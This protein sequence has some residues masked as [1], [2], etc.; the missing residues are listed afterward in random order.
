MKM[1]NRFINI[2]PSVKKVVGVVIQS[3]INYGKV[4]GRK[5]G[6]TGEIGEVL[7]C[8]KLKFKL[9]A[10]PITS[11]YDA[12]DNKGKKYQIKTR[13]G[14]SN[15]GR[16]GRFSNHKFDYAILAILDEG[17]KLKELYQVPFKKLEPVLRKHLR[18]NPSLL[19]FKKVA[20]KIV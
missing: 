13:R 20:D 6:I 11:G 19:E 7:V 8:D 18:R 9:L 14:N 10:D 5:L 3:A 4:T 1:M 15:K 16:V 2:N 12:V 17:Y